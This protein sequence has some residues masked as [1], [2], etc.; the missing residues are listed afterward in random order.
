MVLSLL[1][2]AKDSPV[3]HIEGLQ[4]RAIRRSETLGGVTKSKGSKGLWRKSIIQKGDRVDE[5][6]IDVKDIYGSLTG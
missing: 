1:Q 6:G 5:L 2:K 4:V 3:R